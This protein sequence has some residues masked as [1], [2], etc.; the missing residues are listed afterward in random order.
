MNYSFLRQMH[1]KKKTCVEES[2]N[3]AHQ[4][5]SKEKKLAKTLSNIYIARGRRRDGEKK[6]PSG[7]LYGN[8]TKSPGLRGKLRLRSA[9][10]SKKTSL[11]PAQDPDLEQ[12]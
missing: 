10:A 4:G 8:T 9:T 12:L 2:W 6:F 11:R 5:V 7:E 3:I 1:S